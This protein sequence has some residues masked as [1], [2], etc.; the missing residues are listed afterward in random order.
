MILNEAYVLKN[1]ETKGEYKEKEQKKRFKNEGGDAFHS[2]YDYTNIYYFPISIA[3]LD[4]SFLG[5]YQR[6]WWFPFFFFSFVCELTML[7]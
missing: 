2:Y 1:E 3:Y 6:V 7:A 5:Q 4:S